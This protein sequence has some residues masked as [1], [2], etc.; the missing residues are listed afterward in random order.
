MALWKKLLIIFG[1]FVCISVVL[2]L[3]LYSTL[4][5]FSPTTI[6]S[7]EYVLTNI[8]K[9]EEEEIKVVEEFSDKTYYVS[10]ENGE[11][12]SHSKD[13]GI[14]ENPANYFVILIGKEVGVYNN[15][16]EGTLAYTGNYSDKTLYIYQTIENVSYIFV[17]KGE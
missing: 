2:M 15:D 13:K 1:I 3:V 16:E 5:D 6:P 12:I 10:V 17:Y 11:L 8:S 7:G 4:K 14:I 9:I